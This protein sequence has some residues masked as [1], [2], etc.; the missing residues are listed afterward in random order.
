MATPRRPAHGSR[1]TSLLVALIVAVIGVAIAAHAGGVRAAPPAAS[2][3]GAA[4]PAHP[5]PVGNSPTGTAFPSPVTRPSSSGLTPTPIAG[6]LPPS[7]GAA[8]K[9][10]TSPGATLALLA[11]AF[12]LAGCA[13]E[14]ARRRAGA[15]HRRN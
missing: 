1:F 7:G 11:L 2:T 8:G 5:G 13:V 3:P 14:L 9:S 6:Q 15:A 12:L 4:T 10:P